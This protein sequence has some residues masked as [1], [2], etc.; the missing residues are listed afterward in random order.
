MQQISAT[1]NNLLTNW[2]PLLPL[3]LSN[4]AFSAELQNNRTHHF[5]AVS[6]CEMQDVGYRLYICICNKVFVQSLG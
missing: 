4:K 6:V 1:V 2:S 5:P 3:V